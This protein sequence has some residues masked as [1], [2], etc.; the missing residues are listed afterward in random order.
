[1]AGAVNVASWLSH[2]V[3]AAH[4]LLSK[5]IELFSLV[6]LALM[7]SHVATNELD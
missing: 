3:K 7:Q 1:M 2:D 4:D 5:E 6:F